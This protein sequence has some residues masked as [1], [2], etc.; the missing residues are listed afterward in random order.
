MISCTEFIPAYS[1]LFRYL[2]IKGGKQAVTDYWQHLSDTGLDALSSEVT[3]HGIRGCYN[4]WT[5]TLNEEAAD[6]T[7]TL[8][9]DAGEFMIEMHY[10]PSKGRLLDIK[11]IDPYPDYCS[12]CDLLYRNILEP[13]GYEY[14]IDLTRCGEAAC[15]LTVKRKDA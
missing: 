1:E 7:M 13:F 8:D 12:H 5:H 3:A 11:Q 9:E 2:E 6:F 14:D 4:Y 15:K 10:C